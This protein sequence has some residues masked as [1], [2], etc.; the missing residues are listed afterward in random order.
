[1]KEIHAISGSRSTLHNGVLNSV[2]KTA[3]TKLEIKK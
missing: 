2:G 1:M 3:T